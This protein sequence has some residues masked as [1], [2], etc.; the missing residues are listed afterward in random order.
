[1]DFDA[2][3]MNSLID[4]CECPSAERAFSSG[5]Y[6]SDH[7]Y[8]P[9]QMTVFCSSRRRASH[10]RPPVNCS[11]RVHS[12]TSKM[13]AERQQQH[14]SH[15]TAAPLVFH[16]EAAVGSGS[17][18]N[19][20]TPAPRRNVLAIESRASSTSNN[21]T[22]RRNSNLL[23]I[24]LDRPA[25]DQSFNAATTANPNFISRRRPFSSS[26]LQTPGISLSLTIAI[27]VCGV[28]FCV[29]GIY[30]QCDSHKSKRPTTTN[31]AQPSS[32]SS[33]LFPYDT[34]DSFTCTCGICLPFPIVRTSENR[35][36]P[37]SSFVRTSPSPF[38]QVF[39]NWNSLEPQFSDKRRDPLSSVIRFA[40]AATVSRIY[41]GDYLWTLYYSG[42]SYNNAI[43]GCIPEAREPGCT[44]NNAPTGKT[45]RW[46]A[47]RT[48]D[49]GYGVY[50]VMRFRLINANGNDNFMNGGPEV[51]FWVDP[52]VGVK[53]HRI[54]F[55]NKNFGEVEFEF[56]DKNCQ[57]LPPIWNATIHIDALGLCTSGKQTSEILNLQKGQT[58]SMQ[59][60]NVGL[61]VTPTT[62]TDDLTGA[63]SVSS[64]TQVTRN[65]T[66]EN[67]GGSLLVHG[68][69][70]APR[71]QSSKVVSTD[72]V[73]FSLGMNVM[74]SPR[75]Y[76]PIVGDT[77]LNHRRGRTVITLTIDPDDARD[78][79]A[80]IRQP[81]GSVADII[82]KY[83]SPFGGPSNVVPGGG[84][85]PQPC[86]FVDATTATCALQ[87]QHS[88]LMPET[89]WT[90]GVWVS[91]ATIVNNIGWFWPGITDHVLF[92]TFLITLLEPSTPPPQPRRARRRRERCVWRQLR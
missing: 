11:A 21:S 12:P 33:A 35:S 85:G 28:L 75:P 64:G 77:I 69:F 37:S 8:S 46:N 60:G 17:F 19:V 1:M 47:Y 34:S 32:I 23:L 5:Q 4:S 22:C 87:A 13:P 40:E 42:S 79:Y 27:I 92:G 45:C 82:L 71:L 56:V 67:S 48:Q 81:D 70:G 84:A 24:L 20:A 72:Y 90:V 91:N 53:A 44:D 80:F 31:V 51:A 55:G 63:C 2:R 25:C 39:S 38:R 88:E 41:P 59:S 74:A 62:V 16:S 54:D 9:D 43:A 10:R 61:I 30:F 57:T 6:Y 58:W 18:M 36:P 15:G 50:G 7:H 49:M 73:K 26:K 76:G 66:N 3:R 78:G 65:T 68:I 89:G 14:P 86:S 83:P 29:V 52:L